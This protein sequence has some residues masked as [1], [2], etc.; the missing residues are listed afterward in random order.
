MEYSSF[1]V[2]AFVFVEIVPSDPEKIQEIL[3]PGELLAFDGSHIVALFRQCQYPGLGENIPI[4]TAV[5]TNLDG[6]RVVDFTIQR[7]HAHAVASRGK[8]A[9]TYLVGDRFFLLN[10]LSEG[11]E[12]TRYNRFEAVNL[13]T[14]QVNFVP[15]SALIFYHHAHVVEEFEW[16]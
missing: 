14:G 7:I 2:G 15:A 4:L 16:S 3:V 6:F 10:S 1:D 12:V 13:R 9:D 5:M 11:L 8:S